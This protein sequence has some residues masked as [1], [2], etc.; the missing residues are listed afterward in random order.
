MKATFEF[1]PDG[2]L[3]LA[4]EQLDPLHVPEYFGDPGRSSLRY[5]ADLIGPKPGTD[6]IV[7]AHA[8]AAG[9]RPI[10]EVGV[11]LRI[12]ELQKTLLVRGQSRYSFGM[13][14]LRVTEPAPFV[15]HPI[16]YESAYGGSDMLDDEPKRHRIDAR[17][18]VGVGIAQHAAHLHGRV[19]PSVFYPRGDPAKIGPAGF[20]AIASYWSPRREVAGTYDQRWAAHKRP[21][22]PDDYD[23]THLLCS[24]VDQRAQPRLRGGERIGL[25]NL[26]P[27]GALEFELPRVVFAATTRI[28]RRSVEHGFEL[29]SVVIEPEQRRLIMTWQS[30][31]LVRA[32]EVDDL[33]V[34]RIR[35]VRS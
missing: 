30:A 13:T 28:S 17:N 20:G 15:T 5:E 25:V 19:A 4:D 16:R 27:E 1:K 14:G 22:L 6:V 18:P 33:R 35:E 29:A 9:G 31:L 7:N 2:T 11:S 26:T 23:P 8:H 34:S 21:L 32:P 10:R 24:P 12:G 3:G